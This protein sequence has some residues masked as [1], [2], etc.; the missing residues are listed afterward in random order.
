MMRVMYAARSHGADFSPMS[1]SFDASKNISPSLSVAKVTGASHDLFFTEESLF[2][3]LSHQARMSSNNLALTF[4]PSPV[5]HG[6]PRCQPL[7]SP[8]FLPWFF[9]AFWNQ[10]Y[11]FS[12]S[13]PTWAYS[14]HLDKFL[15]H[16]HTATLPLYFF[17]PFSTIFP[18]NF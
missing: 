3:N 12:S 6:T 10:I 2:H 14:C 5:S 18:S 9:A 17:W 8:N 11:T 15:T 1:Y 13:F 16:S 4:A 7:G